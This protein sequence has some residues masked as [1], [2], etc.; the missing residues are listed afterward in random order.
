M[1]AEPRMT[2][3]RTLGERSHAASSWSEPITLMSC[4]A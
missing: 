1:P 3:V 2:I 4:I